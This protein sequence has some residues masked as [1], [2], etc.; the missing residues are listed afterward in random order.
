MEF[1]LDIKIIPDEEIP[2]YFIRNKVYTKFHKALSTLQ[3]TDI[4][5]SF[6]NYKA[7]LGDTI[8]IHGTED[9]LSR[10]QTTNWIGGLSGYC[11]VSAAQNIPPDAKHR[12]ISRVQTNMSAAKLRRILKRGSISEDEAKQYMAKMFSQ[13]LDNP[14]L[15]LVSNS[16]GQ[17][18]RRYIQFGEIVDSPVTGA[19]DSF[20]L[21]KTATVPWF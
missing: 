20:G 18:H 12:T 6:P 3:A 4:G 16:N 13:G 1:Y 17:Q 2:I 5:V 10:L 9:S 11:S 7:K 19:F 15:E 14:Y 8:R 21:S